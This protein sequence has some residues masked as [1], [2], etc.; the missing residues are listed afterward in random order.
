MA[1][2][3]FIVLGLIS[4]ENIKTVNH[5]MFFNKHLVFLLFVVSVA[6]MMKIYL[7]KKNQ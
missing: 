3:G 4:K 7:T 5:H 2:K 1:K 6:V